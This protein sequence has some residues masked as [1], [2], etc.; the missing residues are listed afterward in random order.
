MEIN[1]PTI[2]KFVEAFKRKVSK[3]QTRTTVCYDG[4]HFNRPGTKL[5]RKWYGEQAA[6]RYNK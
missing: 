3:N 6:E 1:S 2:D 5:V 4:K